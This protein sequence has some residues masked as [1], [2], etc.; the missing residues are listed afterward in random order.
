MGDSGLRRDEAANARRENLSV[1]VL[2]PGGPAKTAAKGLTRLSPKAAASEA[3]SEAAPTPTGVPVWALSIVG[4]R[5][6]DHWLTIVGE[7]PPAT[8]KQVADSIE[9]KTK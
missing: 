1:A 4:K 2:S 9:F 3:A 7:V 5:Q 6:G 8:V